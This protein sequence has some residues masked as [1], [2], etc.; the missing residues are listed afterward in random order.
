MLPTPSGLIRPDVNKENGPR[1]VGRVEKPLTR[2]AQDRAADEDVRRPRI[3][4]SPIGARAASVG[5]RRVEDPGT[6]AVPLRAGAC[7]KSRRL[8]TLACRGFFNT[9]HGSR[10]PIGTENASAMQS[11]LAPVISVSFPQESSGDHPHGFPKRQLKKWSPT[12][13]PGTVE[14]TCRY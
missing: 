1:P 11:T 14:L 3:I 5:T 7:A 4:A 13:W 10:P 2:P 8:P 9:P 12:G 6:G